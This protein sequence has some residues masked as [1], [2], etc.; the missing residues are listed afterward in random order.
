[1][2]FISP[3]SSPFSSIVVLVK[4]KDSTMTMCIEYKSSNEK[5]IKI[6][7]PI[8]RIDKLIDELHGVVYFSNSNLRSGYHQIYM[9]KE[10]IEKTTYICHYGNFE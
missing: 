3:S 5:A 8:P 7:Y 2:G 9:R 4:K 1:M 6:R 10:D